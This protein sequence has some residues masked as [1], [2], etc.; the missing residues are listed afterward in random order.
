MWEQLKNIIQNSSDK[1]IVIEDGKPKFVVLTIEEYEKMLCCAQGLNK[2]KQGCDSNDSCQQSESYDN[3]N[4]E[5]S[6]VEIDQTAKQEADDLLSPEHQ[7][8]YL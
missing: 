3:A 7:S 6:A 2:K 8:E 5:L 1:A 4:K